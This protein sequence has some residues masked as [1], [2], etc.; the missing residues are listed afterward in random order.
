MV[1]LALATIAGGVASA[2]DTRTWEFET[3]TNYVFDA[4]LVQ[5][6][7]SQASLV[8]QADA[9]T[10]AEYAHYTNAVTLTNLAFDESGSILLAGTSGSYASNGV[11][12]SRIIPVSSLGQLQALSVVANFNE[13]LSD[14]TVRAY[15]KFDNDNWIDQVTSQICAVF[16]AP[17]FSTD[18]AIGT[19]SGR[20]RGST[21]WNDYLRAPGASN[22]LA[23][24]EAFTV[25]FWIKVERY[26]DFGGVFCGLAG[27]TSFRIR[28]NL[29]TSRTMD[30]RFSTSQGF[31]VASLPFNTN[32]W[33]HMAFAWDGTS[34]TDRR[35]RAYLNGNLQG[36]SA[37]LTGLVNYIGQVFIANDA[38]FQTQRAMA[39]WLDD[40]LVLNRALSAGEV[41]QLYEGQSPIFQPMRIRIRTGSDQTTIGERTFVGPDATTNSSYRSGNVLVGYG[42]DVV[43]TDPLAQYQIT[44]LTDRT[45]QE[46]PY[47]RAVRFIGN[48]LNV[49]DNTLIDFGQGVTNGTTL[50]PVRDTSPYLGLAK[51]DNGGYYTNGVYLSAVIDAG[52]PVQWHQ[53]LWESVQQLPNTTA[54]LVA[55]WHCNNN[56][57]DSRGTF[58]VFN[59]PN[60]AYTPFAKA[61]SASALFNGI[62]NTVSGFGNLGNI[63]TVSFWIQN[64]NVNDEIMQ[65]NTSV[66]FAIANRMIRVNGL[67]A[68]SY[69]IFVNGSSASPRLVPGWNHVA[70]NFRVAVAVNNLVIG[71]IPGVGFM[72]GKLDEIAMYSRELLAAEINHHYTLAERHAAG[73]VR[74]QVSDA[75]LT[76]F[77]GINGDPNQFFTSS[78]QDDSTGNLL[79]A[80]GSQRYIRFKLIMDGEGDATPLVRLVRLSTAPPASVRYLFNTADVF[81]LGERVKGESQVYGGQV[82]LSDRTAIGPQNLSPLSPGSLGIWH[83]DEDDWLTGDRPVRAAKGDG[84]IAFGSARPSFDARVGRKSG[85]FDGVNSYVD[86]IGVGASL[87]TGDF[88]AGLWFKTSS[89]N[90]APMFSL[91]DATRYFSLRVNTDGVNAATGAVAFVVNDGTGEKAVTSWRTGLNDGRW[92]H[93]VGVR[94]GDQ[95]LIYV[96][97]DRVGSLLVPGLG[98]CGVQLTYIVAK[99]PALE[100]YYAGLLDEL[101][102]F[103]RALTEKD[104]GNL[105]SGGARTDAIGIYESQVYT[106]VDPSIWQ[107]LEW[108]PRGPYSKPLTAPPN[109]PQLIGLWHLDEASG[110]V[111]NTVS[112]N[113]LH[114]TVVG[115]GYRA[116]GRFNFALDFNA[117]AQNYVQVSHSA[118]LEPSP[119]RLSVE[120]WVQM[121]AVDNRYV[122]AKRTAANGYALYTTAAG[123]P[124]FWAGGASCAAP[125]ALRVGKWHHLTG[126]YTGTRL[127]LYV[128]GLLVGSAP[129]GGGSLASG[130]NLQFGRSHVP[131]SYF[132]GR[133]DAIAIHARALN[134]EEVADHYRAGAATLKFQGR[135]ATNLPFASPY[136]GPGRTTN[137]FFV[138]SPGADMT[139]DIDTGFHFQFRGILDTEDFRFP[140]DLQGVTV[141]ASSYPISN[142][143]IHPNP[144]N[145]FTFPGQLLNFEHL[146]IQNPNT[147]VRYQITGDPDENPRWFYWDASTS[148]WREQDV[149]GPNVYTFQASTLTQVSTNI[150][151]FYNQVY[152][153]TGGVFRF[154]AFLHSTGESQAALDW[155]R[156]TAASG[157]ITVVEP[158]GVENGDKSWLVSVP[159]EI[160][161]THTTNLAGTVR[162]QYTTDR[163]AI[164]R[165]LVPAANAV[166]ITDGTHTWVTPATATTQALVRIIYNPD[167]TIHDRSDNTF[168]LA[169]GLQIIDHNGGEPTWYIGETNTVR[170][171][172]SFLASPAHVEFSAN[173]AFAGEQVRLTST[174]IGTEPINS[175]VWTIPMTNAGLVSETGFMRVIQ[176]NQ[177]YADL[178]DASFVLAGAVLTSPT[179]GQGV[180][181]D[182]PY[183]LQWVS[184]GMGPNVQIELQV[185]PGGPWETIA[186]AAPNLPGVNTY[187][188]TPTNDPTET[189]RIRF[190]SPTD[191]RAKGLSQNF[192]IAAVEL[193]SPLGNPDLAQAEIWLQGTTQTIAWISGGAGDFVS[194]LYSTNSGASFTMIVSN[195]P[196]VNGFGVT[197]TYNWL[198][199]PFPSETV[200]VRVEDEDEP[201]DLF[202]VSPYNFQIAGI[203]VVWPNG[204]YP[205]L[206]GLPAQWWDKGVQE[207]ITWEQNAVGFQGR[208]EFSDNNGASWLT[209]A[210]GPLLANQQQAY[211]PTNPTLRALVRITADNPVPYTNV[212]DVSDYTFAV[213]GIRVVSPDS[214]SE[215]TI[216]TTNTV[217]FV[218]A[219]TRDV[220]GNA[221]IYYAGDGSTFDFLNPLNPPSDIFVDGGVHTFNWIVEP[222]RRPSAFARLQVQ[223]GPVGNPYIAY[224]EPFTLRGIA[225][226]APTQTSI[227]APGTRSIEWAIAGI[228]AD[229]QATLALSLT[230]GTAGSY[231]NIIATGLL[232]SIGSYS[233][234]VPEGLGP[235]T[236]ARLRIAITTSTQKPSDIGYQA[237]SQIF[238]LQG[239]RV[240]NPVATSRWDLG[241]TQT[242]QWNAAAAGGFVD[243]FY[244]DNGGVAYDAVPIRTFAP[245]VNGNNS[246][247]WTI[248]MSRTPS[249][250]ARVRVVS[251]AFPAISARSEPFRMRGVK[252]TRPIATDIYATTDTTNLIAWVGVKDHPGGYSL[253][254]IV[255]DGPAQLIANGVMT[256]PYNWSIPLN[257][258][259]D[260]VRIKVDDGIHSNTSAVF[261]VVDQPTIS[262]A[263][264]K[265]G[266]FWEIGEIYPIVWNRG[267]QMPNEFNVFYS[268]SPFNVTNLLSDGSDAV[269]DATNNAYTVMW[270]VPDNPTQARITVANTNPARDF[271]RDTS[272]IFN[273]TGKFRLLNPPGPNDI[274]ALKQNTPI[275]WE[276]R[277]SVPAVDLYYSLSPAH[278]AA[279]WV[280]INSAPIANIFKPFNPADPEDSWSR[281]SFP[282]TVINARTTVAKV[283]VQE[284]GYSQLFEPGAPGPYADSGEFPIYY[285]TVYWNV[286]DQMTLQ[287]LDRLS[288]VDSS[289]W[290]AANASAIP[291]STIQND[292]PWGS[293]NTEI[294]REGFFDASILFWESENTALAAPGPR[295]WTQNVAMVRA[296][297]VDAYHVMANFSYDTI[298]TNFTINTWIERGG[299][300]LEQPSSSTVTIFDE[301]GAQIDQVFS[302]TPLPN[303]VFWLEWSAA[304]LNPRSVY[305]AK[306]EIEYSGSTY[307]SGLT[308]T[309]LVPISDEISGALEAVAGSLTNALGLGLGEV[310]TNVAA[311][312]DEVSSLAGLSSAAFTNLLDMGAMTTGML[313]RVS[314]DVSLITNEL[315]S[316]IAPQLEALTNAIT[317]V[318]LPSLARILSRPDA[319]GLGSTNTILYKTLSGYDPGTVQMRVTTLGGAL[320]D[321]LVLN[322]LPVPG[323]YDGTYVAD[324]GVNH[325]Q[326]TVTDPGASDSMVLRVLTG[327]PYAVPNLIGD[328]G[329]QLDAIELS[330][331]TMSV[332]TDEIT[333]SVLPL[334][335]ML[336]GQLSALSTGDLSF[337]QFAV[338]Q[339]TN[340]LATLEGLE[341]IAYQ[342]G[343]LTNSISQIGSITN[344]SGM[345]EG[346][347]NALTG[348]DWQDV[349]D[350]QA[351]ITVLTN[352]LADADWTDVLA[353][354]ADVA[355]LT[356]AVLAPRGMVYNLELLTNRLVN[357]DFLG[358]HRAVT[359]TTNILTG[360]DGLADISSAI[361]ELSNSL[362]QIQALTNLAPTINALGAELL[363]VDWAQFERNMQTTTNLLTSLD[364][365]E[366]IAGEIANLSN[367]L[368]SIS[369]VTNLT[370]QMNDIWTELQAVDLAR[371]GSDLQLVTNTLSALDSLADISGSIDGLSNSLALISGF[372]NMNSQVEDL[373]NEL[374]SIDLARLGSDVMRVTNQLALLR[375][376]VTSIGGGLFVVSNL[377]NAAARDLTTVTNTLAPFDWNVI[378]GIQAQ[379]DAVYTNLLALDG[380][381]DIAADLQNLTNSIAQLAGVTNIGA[382]V[383]NITNALQ[384]LN[385][386]DVLYIRGQVDVIT[387]ELTALSQLGDLSAI[388]D[389]IDALTNSIAQLE[390]VT[391]MSSQ[392]DALGAALLGI[393]FGALTNE[394]RTIGNTLATFN[395]ADINAIR[396]DVQ[397]TTNLLAGLTELPDLIDAMNSLTNA[398]PDL[399]GVTNLTEQVNAIAAAVLTIDLGEME[400]NLRVMTNQ[401]ANLNLA[402]LDGILAD[403]GSITN[404]LAKANLAAL[405]GI[406]AGVND[407]SNRLALV[408]FGLLDSI[409]ADT[410][411]ITNT[412]GVLTTLEDVVADLANLT[413]AIAQLSGVTNIGAE[414]NQITNALQGLNWADI[415]MLTFN[416]STVTNSLTDMGE[417]L[418]ALGVVTN[419]STAVTELSTN[420][421]A[422]NWSDILALRADMTLTTNLLGNLE[423]LD[424]IAP[425]L[426]GLS[427]SLAQLSGVTNLGAEVNQIT[428]ALQGIDWN[429]ITLL[430]SDVSTVTNRLMLMADQLD[431]IA[432]V[433]NVGTAIGELSTNLTAVNWADILA[434]REDMTLMT[435]L[436]GGLDTLDQIAP[437]LAGLSNSLDA[438][439][440]VTNLGAEVAA[441]TNALGGMDWNDIVQI[442][443]NVAM[444][445]N[446]FAE[447]DEIL[448]LLEG[449]TN[450]VGGMGDLST[451][452]LQMAQ[453][454][455]QLQGV[456]WQDIERMQGE[457]TF[458]SNSVAGVSELASLGT[459]MDALI[460]SLEGITNVATDVAVLS[461]A[462]AGADWTDVESLQVTLD[463][464]GV[465]LE[466]L[467]GVDLSTMDPTALGRIEGTLGSMATLNLVDEIERL[468]GTSADAAS[469][470]TVFGRM[471]GMEDK[472]NVVGVDAR[473][474]ALRSQSAKSRARDA[475]S[476]IDDLKTAFETGDLINAMSALQRVQD[477]LR[478]AQEELRQIPKDMDP[479]TT[480]ATVRQM[481]EAVNRLASSKG[482]ETLLMLEPPAVGEGAGMDAA[483]ARQLHEQI[484]QVRVGMEFMQELVDEMRYEPVVHESFL[485]LE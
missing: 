140:P 390:S 15:F 163:G 325:Y 393:N 437:A 280:K 235:S 105:F 295:V 439:A 444:L 63:R 483:L 84:G 72:E 100:V 416:M 164:W 263:S 212:F 78:P 149:F 260:N 288:I 89:A 215:F 139:A 308:F 231:T 338:S 381:E 50:I 69:T 189:A 2:A 33:T 99:D 386:Q 23:N 358:I 148:R 247:E 185:S 353:L 366:Q 311:L 21:Q 143:T 54:G 436:L 223:A 144:L 236:N 370:G 121:D 60:A 194:L 97:G 250:N 173:G 133:L 4:D 478:L 240:N 373:W 326:V 218:I 318:G 346:L 132:D 14:P 297:S 155:V 400:Q 327:D 20:F 162:I 270:Q 389:S 124:T 244:S 184:A 475:A 36:V 115:A 410:T 287:P 465:S 321:A 106:R 312:V 226:D 213:A 397:D 17:F 10:S 192:T 242:I 104:I 191:P 217:R 39:G 161:W 200:R 19:H 93:L 28:Q 380:L 168:T 290:G 195:Y 165:D 172:R 357:V 127:L 443:A 419:L 442:Q 53:L 52:A 417:Q 431:A 103:Q 58:T 466:G 469:A 171:R 3:P 450:A 237:F 383:A 341:D 157:R 94:N 286:F 329:A 206:P 203:R 298:S 112:A 253:S 230:G 379:V 130:A 446:Q 67:A 337:I 328:V 82:S 447:F 479:G 474:A 150:A 402:V 420:L 408:N 429:D 435:N 232:A 350:I 352:G 340:Q 135:S 307:S 407:I 90:P 180:K 98:N 156:L 457:L 233:W 241:S 413:N 320:V 301:Q 228:A 282:W 75:T 46:T 62:N 315:I 409:Q 221:P 49:G 426:A 22:P 267:G 152:N 294:Y 26:Q 384:G 128:D 153:K 229:A 41:T 182:A 317:T 335:D 387:N 362:T 197:N 277:G 451:I 476:A 190:N 183:T 254:Y 278:E 30:I 118:L 285:Y 102:I 368:A 57:L 142:P 418:N 110:V 85:F 245:S 48:N 291:P 238:N 281:V 336:Q 25:A 13:Y 360:L 425:A 174:A 430:A 424:E 1:V 268:L 35:V 34:E 239:L 211:T 306:V 427:N 186:A 259:S 70:V 382:E 445:T 6:R 343:L 477:G 80:I 96:D 313:G 422:V 342:V 377:V 166:P 415:T 136:V 151:L 302:D 355:Q 256:S 449:V 272:G 175:Y 441:L 79:G 87:G 138:F 345:V 224:S 414:V 24:A 16:G 248:A 405:P 158:D 470:N 65:L 292:Y 399:S 45:R 459:Q 55:L 210:Q 251:R 176:Q 299:Q 330:L 289:G 145:G 188:W 73:R 131:G 455:N 91:R 323:L 119:E 204:P 111:S 107:T 126:V 316:V 8:L 322:E 448:V 319:V 411:A 401:L 351:G 220:D 5:V 9:L 216:G 160:T 179:A 395:W 86:S 314:E 303:G 74:F 309:L 452:E 428:N 66:S 177:T 83:F 480:F 276:T 187:V 461:A 324:W 51:R 264:P 38:E 101:V 205:G 412:L 196:N 398:F 222:T 339:L 81:Y 37:E 371:V 305:F 59:P 154:R 120:A 32:E 178:S 208:V 56:W 95:L 27:S 261:R 77:V 134:T 125:T 47:V 266:D 464:L 129:A 44:M 141:Y 117:A 456:D 432:A 265:P 108:V 92:H 385:W 109:D 31:G 219:A 137:A 344:L 471:T 271:V 283:R 169:Q 42:P 275:I 116:P 481:A 434:L 225:F 484:Q 363:P 404:T 181:K 438:I 274:Y 18:R 364:G 334:L 361:G 462:F 485:G 378:L 333:N 376:D 198:V 403:V 122:L 214:A 356:N 348:V 252:V 207:F 365:L 391:N 359:A 199:A 300:I 375:V 269:Y 123:V 388:S 12:T 463:A 257:A 374:Q 284:A 354:R 369:G 243:L 40:L 372:T 394:V 7:D 406:Q 332:A 88:S 454:T 68:N 170:W 296:L 246:S 473:N 347:T 349:R 76:N 262:I 258:I 114:G 482:F 310:L 467:S 201:D 43:N 11:F 209:V 440:G 167:E 146:R 64:N 392:V 472:L 396:S 227:W 458:I 331:Q 367:A 433:T 468:L 71:E 113:G 159:Y 423:A 273:L 460:A 304:G 61:G 29:A 234:N 147:D 193:L 255:N 421:S 453:L 279:S 202:S 249:T 293:F